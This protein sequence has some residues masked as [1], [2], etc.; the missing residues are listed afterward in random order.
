MLKW[1][2]LR[3]FTIRGMWWMLRVQRWM[4]QGRAHYWRDVPLDVLAMFAQ[5]EPRMSTEGTAPEAAAAWH[6]FIISARIE[7]DRR[8]RKL[9]QD[10]QADLGEEQ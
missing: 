1:L 2:K 9:V 8:L 3:L 6:T 5:F 4:N 7:R 10:I